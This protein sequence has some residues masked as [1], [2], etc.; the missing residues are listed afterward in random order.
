MD[1][2]P[3]SLLIMST[4]V[5]LLLLISFAYASCLPLIFFKRDGK[6]N[7]MWWLTAFPFILCPLF[8]LASLMGRV[9]TIVDG[10][11]TLLSLLS[12]ISV[13]FFVASIALISYT[14]GTHKVP[15]ALW[16]Q[17]N[18][19]PQSIVTYGAY[20][21]IRHPF[22]ASFLLAYT[23]AAFYCPQVGTL[24]LLLYAACMLNYTA[25]KEET[26][27]SQSEFG[28]EYQR[29]MQTTGRFFPRLGSR[30]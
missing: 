30:A 13:P 25:Q 3:G 7:P 20:S 1:R 22:Y 18:D 24:F 28:E 9:P 19:A 17:N 5:Y 23:G 4:P 29:Y 15:I 16:H 2:T 14:L 6:F 12:I 27:L 26:K 8:V 11:P 10:D 21:R